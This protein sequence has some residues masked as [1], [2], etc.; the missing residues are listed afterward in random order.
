MSWTCDKENDC[1]NGADETHCGQSR[2]GNTPSVSLPASPSAWENLTCSLAKTKFSL[3]TNFVRPASSSAATTAASPPAG[4]VMVL[5]TAATVLTRTR[6]AV[7]GAAGARR[8]F[9][10]KEPGVVM[11]F[12]LSRCC[13]SPKR[14]ARRRSS[15]PA[16]TCACLSAGSAMETRTAQ[17]AP[18]KVLKL[19]AVS[20]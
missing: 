17:T 11:L 3:Q 20:A 4:C 1:E 19:A 9:S 16:P 8:C 13:Q 7:S 6:S 2:P 5:T 14:A 18:M 15:V 10:T 12:P